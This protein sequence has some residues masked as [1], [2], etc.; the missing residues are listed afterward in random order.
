[1]LPFCGDAPVAMAGT[2]TSHRPIRVQGAGA[3]EWARSRPN[4][5]NVARAKCRPLVIGDVQ[6]WGSLDC[7]REL[8]AAL[9]VRSMPST[10][11]ASAA[12]EDTPSLFDA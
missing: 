10:I 4:L 3:R 9:P 7:F 6:Q 11:H 5:L 8:R 1:M 12:E 2:L